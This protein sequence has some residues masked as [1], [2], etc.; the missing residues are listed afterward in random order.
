MR[1]PLGGVSKSSSVDRRSRYLENN[2]P[3]QGEKAHSGRTEQCTHKKDPG[4]PWG[5]SEVSS[6]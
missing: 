3:R 2:I 1:N 4:D 5:W 6:G